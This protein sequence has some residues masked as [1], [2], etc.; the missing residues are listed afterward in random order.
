MHIKTYKTHKI[1]IEDSLI[2]L[3]DAYIP[4]LEEGSIFVITSKI[5]SLCEG[6]VV[7]K[8]EVSSKETLI[9]KQADAYLNEASA[10]HSI[11]LTIKNNILIPSAGIDE[12]NGNGVY[13]LYPKNIQQSAVAIWEYVR[14]R[15]KIQELGVLITDSQVIPMRR[16]VIG[17]GLGWC[18]F[19]SLYN[20]IGKLDCFDFPLRLTM[21]NNL[22]ALSAA[23]VFC[24]GE[25]NE[26][27]PFAVVTNAPKIEF[28]STPPTDAEVKEIS[29][30]ME[31]DLY[32]SL[33]KNAQWIFKNYIK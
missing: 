9:Q 6:N 13:V 3:I 2:P 24:M 30:P 8:E 16:G 4:Q 33:L 20:Y 14:N 31:E 19:K 21:K 7:K 18:G 11:Q 29:I 17:I 15:D 27:T 32:A 28:Q 10:S 26:Q 12:S 25:G 22:D 5:I 1:T 23:A